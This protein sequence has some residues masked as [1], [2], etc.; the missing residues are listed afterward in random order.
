[1]PDLGFVSGH[2][3]YAV[4][5]KKMAATFSIWFDSIPQRLTCGELGPSCGMDTFERMTCFGK[6]SR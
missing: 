1:M 5:W 4:K 3:L 2:M 6:G